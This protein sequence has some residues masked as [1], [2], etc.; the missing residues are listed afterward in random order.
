MTAARPRMAIVTS[1]PPVRDSQTSI[2]LALILFAAYVFLARVEPGLRYTRYVLPLALAGL[3]LAR[4]AQGEKLSLATPPLTSYAVVTAAVCVWSAVAIALVSP[5]YPRF[6]EEVLFLIAPLGAAMICASLRRSDSDGPL[7]ALLAILAADYLWEIGLAPMTEAIQHPVLFTMDLV[8]SSM[9]AT[10]SVRAFSFG[11]L[12]VFFLGRRKFGGA[13]IA[14]L[15]AFLAGKRIVLLG[16]L[17][18]APIALAAPSIEGY[19]RRA[20]IAVLAVA[21]NLTAAM[22][23]RNLGDWGIADRIQELTMQSADAVLMGRARLFAL[24]ADRL[25]ETPV[26]GAGLGRITHVLESESAWLTN[27]HSDVLKYYIEI[28]PLMFA[29]W[30]GAFYWLSRRRGALALAVFMNVLFLSD[31]VSIYFDVMFPFYL[32][33]AYLDQHAEVGRRQARIV[34]RRPTCAEPL[35]NAA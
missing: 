23:L 5:Y 18:A 10:E 6:F 28:G 27:T 25:P 26:I 34:R 1:A 2:R 12:A 31:N 20:A 3:W 4:R 33:F 22:S 8:Q 16:L 7:Y 35:P 21:V 13:A 32:S 15:L 24:L 14:L 19:K 17:T 9:A 11:A 30:I 29:C